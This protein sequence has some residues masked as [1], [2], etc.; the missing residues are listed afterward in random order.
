[1]KELVRTI[2]TVIKLINRRNSMEKKKE[3]NK[4]I[5]CCD[6]ISIQPLTKAM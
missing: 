3:A 1:M 5:G 2:I 6:M 4:Q